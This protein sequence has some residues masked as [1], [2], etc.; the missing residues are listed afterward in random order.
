MLHG[1]EE[2]AMGMTDCPHCGHHSPALR[3]LLQ[4]TDHWRVVCDIHPLLEGHLLI[5]PKDHIACLGACSDALWEE[6]LPLSRTCSKFLRE[7]YRCVSAFEHGVIGQTVFHAHVHMLPFSGT[8]ANIVPEGRQ[9]LK[10]VHDITDVRKIFASEGKYLFFSIADHAWIVDPA[11]GVPRFFRERFAQAVG[12][13]ERGDWKSMENNLH[14]MS[15]A[16]NEIARLTAL[17][18]GMED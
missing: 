3:S 7:H 18:K 10:S 17:W 4:E 1:K 8:K 12:A 14:L 15:A 13:P 2:Y 5:I 9:F 6:F 11:L 16:E